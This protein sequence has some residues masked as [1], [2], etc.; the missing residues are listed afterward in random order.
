MKTMKIASCIMSF[1]FLLMIV[2]EA[3]VKEPFAHVARS[4]FADLLKTSIDPPDVNVTVHST[5][6]EEGLTIEDV[7]W[8]SQDGQTVPAFIIR[9]DNANGQL[10]AIVCLHGSS[11]SRDAMVTKEFGPGEWQRPG[12]DQPHTRMLGWARELAR[13][14]YVILALTQ[15]GLDTRQPPINTEANVNLAYGQTSMGVI[16]DE[17]RQGVTYLQSRSDVDQDRIGT[18]GMSFGGI[19]AFYMFLLDDRISVS[20]PI[21]GGIGSIEIFAR[22]GSIGYHGTYWWIPDIVAKG[23]Q[24]G[25]SAAM[26]PKP[27]ML[28]APTQ[29]VG[30]TK[31]AVDKF[32]SIVKP[33]Y[34]YAGKPSNFVVHQPPGGHSFTIEAFEAMEKFFDIH[35]RA[36][37]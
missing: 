15:R 3:Q 26:A 6:K 20:A 34:K 24:A 18:T 37:F 8:Q 11:G 28:W 21:C 9:K 10:P 23:D 12:R 16:L 32:I 29:D 35:F 2:V 27:L 33:A 5:I 30:M 4:T 17:I 22:T 13:R 31:V 7:S 1:C 14:G 36:E 19:T 25:F